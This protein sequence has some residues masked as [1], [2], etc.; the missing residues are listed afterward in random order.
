MSVEQFDGVM[1]PPSG[2]GSQD[3]HGEPG[4]SWRHP[5]RASAHDIVWRC[6]TRENLTGASLPQIRR[7]LAHA[8]RSLLVLQTDEALATLEQIELQ[9]DDVSLVAARRISAATELLRA[10]ALA[11]QDD[12]LV[13][14]SVAAARL[15]ENPADQDSYVAATLCRLGF[16]RLGKLDAFHSLPRHQPRARRSKPRAM[17]AMFD[18]SIE[19]AVA[20]DQLRISVAKRLASDALAVAEAAEVDAGL[21]ALPACLIAEVL[22]EEG[23]LDEADRMLR[24]RLLAINAEGSIECALRA[25]LV[26]ARIARH[27]GQSDLAAILLREAVALGERRRWSRLV[28]AC[29]AERASLLVAAGRTKEARRSVEFLDR[30]A[31]AHRPAS[32]HPFSE[33][34]RYRMLARW[35]ISWAEARSREAVAAVRQLYHQAIERR[36]LYAGCRLAV[37]LA[38]MLASIGESEEAEALFFNTVRVGAAAGLCQVF[39]EGG[40]GLAALL[41]RAYQLAEEPGSTDRDVLAFVGSLL[42]RFDA[43]GAEGPSSRPNRRISDTLTARERDILALIS[44]GW[45]NKRIARALEISPETVKSHIKGTFLKLASSTRA[46]AVYRAKSL[47]LL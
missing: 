45:P 14:L 18:L 30:Y 39:L 25:Y 5:P 32:G 42:S 9:L 33:M 23:C 4:V 44:Q 29:I 24:N 19:A 1:P 16:W 10:V 38:E 26:L 40:A 34:T 28:A 15:R 3:R 6:R 43:R 8:W 36:D 22:Y 17:S 35:R 47:G 2:L 20:L 37:E 13:A 27:R 12:T 41:R 21:A 7:C 31:E 11:F 46:E